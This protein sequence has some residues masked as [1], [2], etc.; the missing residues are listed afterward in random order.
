MGSEHELFGFQAFD[1]NLTPVT[2]GGS[3]GLAYRSTG[4]YE[5]DNAVAAQPLYVY[6]FSAGWISDKDRIRGDFQDLLRSVR[7][8]EPVQ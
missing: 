1:G 8:S 4:L 7:F 5:T 6:R 2:I 3:S